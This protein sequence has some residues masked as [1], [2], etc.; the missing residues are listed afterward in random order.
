MVYL[1]IADI[2]ALFIGIFIATAFGRSDNIQL[3]PERNNET[4]ELQISISQESITAISMVAPD[5]ALVQQSRPLKLKGS[6]NYLN[7]VHKLQRRR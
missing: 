7:D 2:P 4:V 3:S 1:K 5:E 6:Q